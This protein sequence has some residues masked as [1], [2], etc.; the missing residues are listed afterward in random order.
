MAKK[1]GQSLRHSSGLDDLT[2][3]VRGDPET[4]QMLNFQNTQ[5]QLDSVSENFLIMLLE[6]N[7]KLLQK[8]T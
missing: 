1:I 2:L 4:K 6:L 8:A 5:L 7:E 3:C